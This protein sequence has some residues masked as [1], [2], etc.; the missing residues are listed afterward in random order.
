[1]LRNYRKV[2]GG[3]LRHIAILG[4]NKDTQR[5]KNFFEKRPDYGYRTKDVFDVKKAF[6]I[7]EFTDWVLENKIDE[8]W[9]NA[10]LTLCF[11][12]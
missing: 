1:M 3:N 6:N 10:P 4:V 5:L 11:L 7:N 12:F 8:M 2:L 9:Q